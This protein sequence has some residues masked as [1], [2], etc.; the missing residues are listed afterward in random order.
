MKLLNDKGRMLF[1]REKL[2]KID[3]L[4]YLYSELIF[5]DLIKLSYL[6]CNSKDL[7]NRTN[8][9]L[10]TGVDYENIDYDELLNI[11]SYYKFERRD[12]EIEL[13]IGVNNYSEKYLLVLREMYK[14]YIDLCERLY[15]SIKSDNKDDL[16]SKLGI[17]LSTLEDLLV[18]N[19]IDILNLVESEVEINNF[20]K[21][22][23]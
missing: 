13:S 18:G 11:I 17:V 6:H 7:K 10:E 19:Y 1:Y 16:L 14:D 4:L 2:T 22:G 3:R 20:K 21:G 23:I 5:L 12:L 9:F 15:L 8:F